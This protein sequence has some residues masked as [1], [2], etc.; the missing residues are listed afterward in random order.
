MKAIEDVNNNQLNEAIKALNGMV[1]K[2]GNSLMEKPL[3][4]IGV[5]KEDRVK[6]F[7]EKYEEFAQRDDVDDLEFPDAATNFYTD[8]F[9]DE[10]GDQTG[11]EGGGEE[12]TEPT[13]KEGEAGKARAKKKETPANKPPQPPSGKG[14]AKPKTSPTKLMVAK[15]IDSG[16]WTRQQILEKVMAKHPEAAKSTIRTYITDSLSETYSE[17]YFGEGKRAQIDPETKKMSWR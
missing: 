4:F 5:K 15:L 10:L 11:G 12:S 3:R 16:K 1:D 13:S 9:A 6:N 14:K 7:V 17:R 2:D 8:L